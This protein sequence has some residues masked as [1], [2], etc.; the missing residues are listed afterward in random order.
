MF[1]RRLRLSSLAAVLVLWTIFTLAQQVNSGSAAQDKSAA[2]AAGK[3]EESR[4]A[5][6]KSAKSAEDAKNAAADSAKSADDSR[7]AS[8]KS[9][10]LAGDAASDSGKSADRSKKSADDAGKSADDAAKS[11]QKAG[12]NGIL[13]RLNQRR[14]APKKPPL[15]DFVPCM[16]AGDEDFELRS[17]PNPFRKPNDPLTEEEA[18]KIAAIAVNQWQARHSLAKSINPESFKKEL[19]G[20]IVGLTP[21]EAAKRLPEL[22]AEKNKQDTT[23]QKTSAEISKT[24]SWSM[25]TKRTYLQSLNSA[26]L[27]GFKVENTINSM[28]PEIQLTQDQAAT[29][30]AQ[31]ASTQTNTATEAVQKVT[32]AETFDRPDDVSCSFSLMGWNETKDVFGRR[33]ANNYIAIQVNI[34][35]LS[36]DNEFLIH[37]IQI[38]V[39]TGVNPR[40]L[41]RFQTGRDRVVVRSVAQRGQSEDR[42]NLILNTMQMI[43]NIAGGASTAFTN[44]TA[45]DADTTP[46]QKL[47]TAVELFQ[48]PFITGLINIFPDHTL[49]QINHISDLAFSASSTNKTVVPV[50]GAVPLVTFLVEKPL[51]QLPFSRCGASRAAD[52][53]NPGSSAYSFCQ[54][55]PDDDV[56]STNNPQPSMYTKPLHFKKW[57][58]AALQVLERRV[59]VVVAGVHIQ[60]VSNAPTLNAVKCPIAGPDNGVDLSQA[61]KDG[62]ISCSLEGKHLDKVA[63]ARLALNSKNVAATI[64][65][66]SDGNTGTLAFKAD[67]VKGKEAAGTYEIFLKDN[68]G[69]ETDTKQSIKIAVRT[70]NITSV[71]PTKLTKGQSAQLTLIGN[72][73]DRIDKVNLINNADT[74]NVKTAAGEVQNKDSVTAQTSSMVVTFPQTE[75]GNL[76]TPPVKGLI[77]LITKD[78]DTLLP[79]TAFPIQIPK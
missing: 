66:A 51:E 68:S 69:N 36:H 18:Q 31:A 5:A 54:L 57:H 1:L 65:A 63:S 28:K 41:G 60:E 17:R 71:T 2:E 44:V 52:G 24:K 47:S 13:Q 73:L 29:Q 50:Q 14:S 76:G 37:D 3:A 25:E 21:E 70:P 40:Q 79:N 74:N 53:S 75:V 56:Q 35:N 39:D 23:L 48:G 64:T 33:V 32:T 55:E 26:N 72:N 77:Q 34:R 9:A 43:G 27:S 15:N 49:E 7:K 22:L 38:A 62:N 59:F 30:I 19:A 42:R 45:D 67:D 78:G 6:D 58:A 46:A 12:A 20:A 4:K 16:F 10:E 61:D 11:A 8:D